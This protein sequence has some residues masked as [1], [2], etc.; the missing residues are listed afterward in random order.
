MF[1]SYESQSSTNKKFSF[2]PDIK[3]TTREN[4]FIIKH[5]I[6]TVNRLIYNAHM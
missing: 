2:L 6:N 4:S 5:N 1:E 3:K